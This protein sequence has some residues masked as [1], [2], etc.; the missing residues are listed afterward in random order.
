MIVDSPQEAPLKRS[1]VRS[2]D[3]FDTLIARRCIDPREMFAPI[4]E[5]GY[6]R[7][8]EK[9]SAAGGRVH[10]ARKTY[11]IEDIYLDLVTQHVYTEA[12]ARILHDL[13]LQ[14]EMENCIPIRANLDLVRDGDILVSDMYYSPEFIRTLLAKAGL[15]CDYRLFVSPAGKL[16]GSIWPEILKTCSISHHLG[17][18][19][20]SDMVSPSE[21]GIRSRM[22]TLHRPSRMET[23]LMRHGQK[24]LARCIREVRL[25]ASFD[26]EV[27][28]YLHFSSCQLNFPLLVLFSRLIHSE[29]KA[30]AMSRVAFVTRDCFNLKRVFK[31]MFS[32]VASTD[33]FSSRRCLRTASSTYLDYLE[34]LCQG[35]LLVELNTSGT[36]LAEALKRLLKRGKVV[37]PTVFSAIFLD[38]KLKK[39]M[40]LVQHPRS[41][42]PVMHH[43]TTTTRVGTQVPVLWEMLN[44]A[45]YPS[46]IDV[47]RLP[48]SGGYHPAFQDRSLIEEYQDPSLVH[49]MNETIRMC[50]T[51]AQWEDIVA[52]SATGNLPGLLDDLIEEVSGCQRLLD[53]FPRLMID[54]APEEKHFFAGLGEGRRRKLRRFIKKLVRNR[55][56]LIGY[57][58]SRIQVRSRL[59]SKGRRRL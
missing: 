45:P 27:L 46:V 34:S 59:A 28:D 22:S 32:E 30:L 23:L 2:F 8:F 20:K 19:P 16:E 18:N 12:E 47:I 26:D 6:P 39:Y 4:E 48:A 7:F 50:I 17:D 25:T 44:F 36:S 37:T 43:F 31:S 13:E 21:F 10:R 55:R 1:Q 49:S 35:T 29:L 58:F 9:R 11:T 40:K 24:S 3:V 56:Q 14:L 42:R 54:A 51:M 41:P 38:E 5:R 15:H 57:L 53:I 52:E 33:F